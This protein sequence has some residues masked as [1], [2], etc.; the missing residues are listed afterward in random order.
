MSI[1]RELIQE[2]FDGPVPLLTRRALYLLL[3]VMALF[4]SLGSLYPISPL[5]GLFELI[6]LSFLVAAIG[7]AIQ[8]LFFRFQY[9]SFAH[10]EQENISDGVFDN[11]TDEM[12]PNPYC[13]IRIL[14]GKEPFAISISNIVFRV[15][16]IS[17]PLAEKMR[18]DAERTKIVISKKMLDVKYTKARVQAFLGVVFFVGMW[19]FHALW[20]FP[21]VSYLARWPLY[22]GSQLM[23]FAVYF[24]GAL[25]LNWMLRGL[26]WKR[27]RSMVDTYRA[28][29]VLP[30]IAYIELLHEGPIPVER[31][32]NLL[33]AYK[34]QEERARSNRRLAAF[35]ILFLLFGPMTSV[36][37]ILFGLAYESPLLQ[38]SMLITFSFLFLIAMYLFDKHDSRAVSEFWDPLIDG[39]EPVWTL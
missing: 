10:L 21:Y 28:Y 15:I 32:L 7:F 26:S 6:G 30:Q 20:L 16:L 5:F 12:A 17:S 11:A 38:Q 27:N 39:L 3:Y 19:V 37:I 34:K 24:L 1:V 18:A 14:P 35:L 22:F 29:G 4:C 23:A 9:S 8:Y 36:P 2:L 33:G 13:R 31:K 25:I